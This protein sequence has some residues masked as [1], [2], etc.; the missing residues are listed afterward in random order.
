MC[1]DRGAFFVDEH[2]TMVHMDC[3]FQ[4]EKAVDRVVLADQHVFACSTTHV[5]VHEA[6]TGRLVQLHEGENIQMLVHNDTEH[7]LS[8]PP[9]LVERVPNGTTQIQRVVAYQQRS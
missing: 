9:I 3:T 7:A 5:E 4:W 1:Y 6:R 2:G 8:T